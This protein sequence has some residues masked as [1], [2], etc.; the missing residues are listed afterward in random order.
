MAQLVVR[1][2]DEDIKAKLK[3]RAQR[4]GRSTEEEVRAILRHA[5]HD[6][7]AAPSPLGTRLSTRFAGIGLDDDVPE[8]R[9]QPATPAEFD[10]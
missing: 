1:N 2:L 9:G 4:H 3:I 7:G 10:P 6:E 5:V 8:L